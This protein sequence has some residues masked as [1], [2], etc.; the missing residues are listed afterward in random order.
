VD[1]VVDGVLRAAVAP[2]AA[3]EVINVATGHRIS[4]RQLVSAMQELLGSTVAPEFAPAR[5]GDVRDSLADIS[6]ARRV[7]GYEPHVSFEEGLRRTLDW[8]RAQR[9]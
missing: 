5:P 2:E 8:Y 4:I 6:L 9:G 1:N 7:L 3:G